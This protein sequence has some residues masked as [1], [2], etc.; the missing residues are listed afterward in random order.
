MDGR[1]YDKIK[2]KRFSKE[3]RYA[4]YKQYE[5]HCAYCG[6]KLD[7]KDMQVDHLVPLRNGG[8]DELENMICSCRSCNKYKSTFSIEGLREQLFKIPERLIRDSV[9][10]RIALRYRLIEIKSKPVEFYFEKYDRE[11]DIYVQRR[12]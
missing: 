2:R 3:E 7:I 11:H 4:I 9:I 8:A 5:G 10:F 12:K 6:V 1:E